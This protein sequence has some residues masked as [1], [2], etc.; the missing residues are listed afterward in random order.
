MP[1]PPDAEQAILSSHSKAAVS[2][3]ERSLG[4]TLP[5]DDE[6]PGVAL[7]FVDHYVEKTRPI[8]GEVLDLVSAALGVWFGELV[9]K[10][11]DGRWQLDGP[12]RDWTLELE[13]VPLTFRPIGMAAEALRGGS[14][15]GYDASMSTTPDFSAELRDALAAA[16]P[17]DEGYYYSLTGR[18]ET[19]THAVEILAELKQ[20]KN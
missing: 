2:Y 8:E 20:N 14:A 19:L 11:F 5:T 6:E 10:V 1:A 16:G 12:A 4:R 9:R 7:A 3:V 17:V 13:A 15:P 18:F